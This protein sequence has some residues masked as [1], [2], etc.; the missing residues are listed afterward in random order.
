MRLCWP[1]FFPVFAVIRVPPNVIFPRINF[2]NNNVIYYNS[3]LRG[4]H[5]DI[6]ENNST[7]STVMYNTFFSH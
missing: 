1:L 7:Y 2:Q 6:N 3:R 5:I 4:I